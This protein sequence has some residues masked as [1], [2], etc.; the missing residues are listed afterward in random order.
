MSHLDRLAKPHL[1]AGNYY[2]TKLQNSRN[3]QVFTLGYSSLTS[4]TYGF[5]SEPSAEFSF[6][7][8][9]PNYSTSTIEI[10]PTLTVEQI[11]CSEN[12]IHI[13]STTGY[14][15]VLDSQSQTEHSEII[16]IDGFEKTVVKL[17]AHCEGKHYLALTADNMVYSW[18]LGEG[19]RLGLGDNLPKDVP[20]K[21]EFFADKEV[22]NVY[23]GA[24]YSAAITANG[25]LYTWGR[26]TFGRL[27]H[28]NSDDK[29]V[30]TLVQALKQYKVIDVTLGS[31][32]S[33]TLCVTDTGNV[34]TWGDN[35]F[36][37]CGY[38][39]NSSG[40]QVPILIENLNNIFKVYSG[41]QFS[42]A[43]SNDG[44]VY[45]WGKGS[46]GRL[47]HGSNFEH[48]YVPKK[49]QALEGKKVVNMSV[50]SAHCL[51]LLSSGELFGWGRNDYQ[52]I[53]PPCITR[54]PIISLPILT[55]PPFLR[56]SG[57]ACGAAQSIVWCK[58]STLGVPQRMPFVIDLCENTFR[59][60]D[61]LLGMVCGSAST[62]ENRH[63]PSQYAECIAVACL[64]LMRLQ[65]HAIICNNISAKQVGLHEGSR[66]LS[67]LK[68]RILTLAGGCAV[69]KTIQ[70]A[71]QWTLQI[72][73]RILLPT[74]SE[75]AQTLTSL[76]PVG[77]DST[78]TTSGQRFMTSLLVGSLMTEGGLQTALNQAI[79][80][81]QDCSSDHHLPLLHL[82]KQLLKNNSSLTLAR[83]NQL[84]LGHLSKSNEDYLSSPES[85]SPSLDLLHKFQRLLLSYIYSSKNDDLASAEA[86]LE[87]YLQNVVSLCVTTLTKAQEIILQNKEGVAEILQTDIS[88]SLLYEL[89]IGLV[90]LHKRKSILSSFSWTETLIP[91][92]MAL[93]N[94]NRL[95]ADGEIQDADDMG[96]PGIISRGTSQ[97]PYSMQEEVLLIRKSDLENHILDGGC[98][99]IIN[100]LV[101]DVKDYVCEN[102]ATQELIIGNVGKDLS[103]ELSAPQHRSA[104][105]YITSHLRVGKFETN[106]NDEKGA[107][108]NVRLT[109]FS[110]E[111]TLAYL[112]GVRANLLQ[113]SL[114]LQPAEIQCEKMLNSLILRGGLQVLQPSNPFDEEKG[115]ARSSGCSS[116]TTTPTDADTSNHMSLAEAP[117][118][119]NWPSQIIL[120]RVEALLTGLGEARLTDP[121]VSSW[122]AISEKFC[123]ENHLIWHQ[124]FASD[125]PVIEL[126]RLLTAVLIRHQ[127][128][129]PLVLAVIDRGEIF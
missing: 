34:F 114:D 108:Q 84:L 18:G 22:V 71:A 57:L 97:K 78:I 127:S 85:P 64:N 56:V 19:G 9:T 41:S 121:L 36:G 128:L 61:Q 60:F 51:A 31:G 72:G 42:V 3:Q 63:P 30:P 116:T 11:V 99:I 65:F 98:W 95:M 32:D 53:C 38:G 75:R 50:G 7:G 81:E 35:E 14:V 16:Q 120:Q 80:S 113:K 4:E 100:G 44:C 49:V 40:S 12:C 58:S 118:M 21:I 33:H 54:D 122:I 82:L 62:S 39:Q 25:E 2:S 87:T 1:P 67:S 93:D 83:L 59:F 8:G 94:L 24:T 123:K 68:S 109:H 13:L 47:G 15:Y 79:N 101:F 92:L 26:G 69:L 10:P 77:C 46:G 91:L 96:W 110:S 119:T 70:E 102:A 66:L 106:S 125:H 89:L 43:L 90:L 129:G 17:A 48:C 107:Q 23:C 124:E 111:R 115:E 5:T 117:Q 45:T 88:D 76:L 105:D 73:W 126:E 112:L 52:Q 6:L 103:L 37:K 20:T 104:L 27:G 55:T 28:N 74:P 29:N 86:L